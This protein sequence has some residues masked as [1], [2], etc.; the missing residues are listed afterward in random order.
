MLRAAEKLTPLTSKKERRRPYTPDFIA[1]LSQHLDHSNPLDAAVYACLTACF[2]ASARLG[3]FTVRRLDGFDPKKH[4]TATCLSRNQ[5]Q[6]GLKVTVL[7]LPST[8][9][10]QMEGEDVFWARQDG[11][12]DPKAAMANHLVINRPPDDH[13][14]FSYEQKKGDKIVQQP[15]TKAKFLE[16]VKKA[17]LTASA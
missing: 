14:L 7:H 2:Y 10:A 17:A 1:A 9:A 6:N 8:K 16:R 15:L 11:P 13:H 12:T 5:D 4:V 3:E